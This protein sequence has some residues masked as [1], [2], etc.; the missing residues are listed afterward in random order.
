MTVE[1][2]VLGSPSLI[3]RTVCVDVKRTAIE[4]WSCVKVE[5][6]VVGSPSLIVRTVCVDVKQH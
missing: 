1:M 5:V 4:L 3:V 2:A 6:A